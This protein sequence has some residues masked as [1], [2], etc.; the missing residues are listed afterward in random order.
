MV[1]TN[2]TGEYG[3]KAEDEYAEKGEETLDA[4]RMLY[5]A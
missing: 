3:R 5:G 1:V 4:V 2:Q